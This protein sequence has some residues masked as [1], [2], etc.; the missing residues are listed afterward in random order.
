MNHPCTHF[1][2]I[3]KVSNGQTYYQCECGQKFKAQAWD[4]KVAVK[5][6]V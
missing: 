1:K 2:L 6:P 3:R 5:K 4:G